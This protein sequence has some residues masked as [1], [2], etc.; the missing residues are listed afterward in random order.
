MISLVETCPVLDV[1]YSTIGNY[2]G[3]IVEAQLDFAITNK[4][5]KEPVPSYYYPYMK[6]VMNMH[7]QSAKL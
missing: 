6:P 4:L 3:D 1:G 5:N 2:Y 7:K